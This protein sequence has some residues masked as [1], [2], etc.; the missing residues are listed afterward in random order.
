MGILCLFQEREG[1]AATFLAQMEYLP[2]FELQP[3]NGLADY[4]RYFL[5]V[6]FSYGEN[7]K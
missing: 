7:E 3:G 4:I 5:Q 1:M 6:I 2:P